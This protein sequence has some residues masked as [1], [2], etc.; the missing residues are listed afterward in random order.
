MASSV[1]YRFKNSKDA[2][3]VTFDGTGI[4]V[5]E[6][7]RAIIAVSTAG[8]TDFD[9]HLY[10][11]DNSAQYDDDT[12]VIPRSTTVVAVRRPPAAKGMGRAARYITG[13]APV[14]ALKKTEIA[15]PQ[16]S[17]SEADAEAAFLAESEAV[18]DQQKA[19]MAHAKPVFH[20]KKP[21]NVPTHDPPPGYVCYRC[22]KKGHWIQACPTNDDPDFKPP[23]R[24]KRTTGIPRSRLK[25][26]SPTA[27][28]GDSDEQKNIL[29]DAEGQ[30]VQIL[31]DEAAWQKFQETAVRTKAKAAN[32]DA[33]NKEL[34]DL[35]LECSLDNQK[36][37]NP[38]KT[39]CCGKTYC[40]DCIDNALAEGDLI[41]PNCKSE[42]ILIDDLV[43]D[44]EMVEKVRKFD[45][46]KAKEKNN[47]APVP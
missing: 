31:T 32:V 21:V 11:E 14:H 47:H 4:S 23:V 43:A 5:F 29:L 45:A 38:M 42:G 28:D 17:S 10:T 22:Q 46:E 15:K 36:F 41:C 20:K 37:V 12:T 9:L 35:G 19:T 8:G 40:H 30:Q 34:R 2:E 7:K 26:V 39:P 18:W 13:K 24:A 1:F 27:N 33:Q 3:R 16:A 25:V 6:L 44:E